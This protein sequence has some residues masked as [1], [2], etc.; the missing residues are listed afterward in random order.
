MQGPF[1]LSEMQQWNQ[2]GYFKPELKVRERDD[3]LL[4]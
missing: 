4:T 2:L 1:E 3:V